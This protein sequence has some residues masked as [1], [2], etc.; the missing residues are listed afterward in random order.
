MSIAYKPMRAGQEDA[1]A[2]QLRQ[3]AKDLGSPLKPTITGAKLRAVSDFVHTT[4]AEDSGLLVGICTWMI[5]FSS[6]RGVKGMYVSD[7]FVMD[8]MRGKNVGE[9]LLRAAAKDAARLGAEFIKLEVSSENPRPPKFYGRLG[10]D[11]SATDRQMFLEQDIFKTFIGGR[12][13]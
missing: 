5:N 13:T 4:V 10:F 9:H 2:V 11:L 6:W 3:L 12:S 8:H 7:L 1:V